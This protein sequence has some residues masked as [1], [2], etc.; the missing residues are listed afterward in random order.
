MSDGYRTAA[1]SDYLIDK[2]F[3]LEGHLARATF[4]DRCDDRGTPGDCLDEWMR[5]YTNLTAARLRETIVREL[6]IYRRVVVDV[7][8]TRAAPIA[9]ELKST[10]VR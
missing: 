10:E 4:Y 8:P 1:V 7:V 6:P 3:A 5:S 9:G 2:I